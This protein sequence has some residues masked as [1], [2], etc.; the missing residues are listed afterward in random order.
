MYMVKDIKSMLQNFIMVEVFLCAQVSNWQ[1][2]EHNFL[3]NF[4]Q[5]RFLQVLKEQEASLLYS[6]I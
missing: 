2:L 5:L 1:D 4:K 6:S 3:L